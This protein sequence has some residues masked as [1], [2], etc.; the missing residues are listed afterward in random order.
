[1]FCVYCSSSSAYRDKAR[2][3]FA[4]VESIAIDLH[5]YQIDH[6][7]DPLIVPTVLQNNTKMFQG[8]LTGGDTGQFI[9]ASA[10]EVVVLPIKGQKVGVARHHACGVVHGVAAYDAVHH[11][12]LLPQG[13]AS[14]LTSQLPFG[15]TRVSLSAAIV[16]PEGGTDLHIP[17]IVLAATLSLTDTLVATEQKAVVADTCLQA[18][19][20]AGGGSSDVA[21]GGWA[22]GATSLVMAVLLALRRRYI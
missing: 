21:T 17:A 2:L 6:R 19:G 1:L 7:A 22:G 13:A 5:L 12:T 11:P 14:L 15:R 9:G 3:C 4:N 10:L 20:F 18:A 16:T 8:L